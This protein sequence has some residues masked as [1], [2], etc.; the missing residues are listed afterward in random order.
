M[1]HSRI[2]VRRSW[3]PA[4]SGYPGALVL[5]RRLSWMN[6][7]VG[8]TGVPTERSTIPRGCW[9][10][11][12]PKGARASQGKSGSISCELLSLL[13]VELQQPADGR[14]LQRQ[15]CSHHQ[16]IPVRRRT[17]CLP[18]RILSIVRGRHPRSR[19]PRR[20]KLVRTHRNPRTHRAVCRAC[21]RPHRCN[22][23]GILQ[24]KTCL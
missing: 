19:S 18:W 21:E 4:V 11:R 17:Q 3:L 9:R 8:S 16:E 14:Y 22:Q 24:C 20:G 13:C 12:W 2:A 7:G 6:S 5:S 1:A 15:L 10:A 23:P